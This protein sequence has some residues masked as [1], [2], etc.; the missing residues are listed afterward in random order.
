MA[1]CIWRSVS[2]QLLG[3]IAVGGHLSKA[4]VQWLPVPIVHG[5]AM[6][7]VP[8]PGQPIFDVRCLRHD[9]VQPARASK[10][11]AHVD[12][13]RVGTMLANEFFSLQ[14]GTMARIKQVGVFTASVH[15]EIGEAGHHFSTACLRDLR[16]FKIVSSDAPTDAAAWPHRVQR[17]RRRRKL[18]TLIGE[19]TSQ[20][21]RRAPAAVP[22]P[23]ESSDCPSGESELHVEPEEEP[24]GDGGAGLACPG[25]D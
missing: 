13:G 20:S 8:A 19:T 25:G 2:E 6:T 24:F 10:W 17:R 4:T 12:S 21:A 3:T 18:P 23:Q 16:L 9:Y 1:T 5:P 14:I 11:S 22:A 7:D 15:W